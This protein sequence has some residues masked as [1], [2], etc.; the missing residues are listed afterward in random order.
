MTKIII[1]GIISAIIDFRIP[2]LNINIVNIGKAIALIIVLKGVGTKKVRIIASIE[3]D[4]TN[5]HFCLLVDL[6][7]SIV[8]NNKS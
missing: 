7:L 2:I 1:Y 3:K 8:V 4:I 5:K 6:I